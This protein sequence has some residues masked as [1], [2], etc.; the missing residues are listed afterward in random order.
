MS[1]LGIALPKSLSNPF[2]ANG[3]IIDLVA[4]VIILTALLLS[5]GMSEAARIENILVILKVL[6]IVLFV[7]VGLTAIQASNYVPF[8]LSIKSLQLVILVDGKV[9]MQVY[10]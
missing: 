4:I 10:Q 2:G 8:I 1:P 6:A 5:R 3:G 9:F 7:I